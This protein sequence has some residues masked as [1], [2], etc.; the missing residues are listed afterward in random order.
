MMAKKPLGV[1]NQGI[2]KTMRGYHYLGD[3]T[4]QLALNIISTLIGTITYFYTDKVGIAAAAVGTIL[5]ISKVIDAFT[6]IVMGRIVDLTESKY[7]KVRHWFWWMAIPSGLAIVALFCVPSGAGPGFKTSYALITNILVMSV[8]YT[9]IAIPYGCLMVLRTKSTEERSKMGIVRAVFG[10][11]SGMIIA[12]ALIPITNALGGNQSAW[13]KVA[14]VFGLVSVISML[15]TF[16]TSKEENQGARLTEK[17]A[18][19]KNIAFTESLGLLFRNKYWVIMLFAMLIVNTIYS[20]TSAIGVYYAKYIL[21]NDNLVGIMGAVGL[22][23]VAAGFAVIGPMIKKF[24]LTRSCR[25]ALLIGIV[26]TS[27]RVFMPTSFIVTL[28]FGSIATFGIIPMTAVG[29]VLV[30]NT[31]EYNEWKFGKRLMGM[32]NSASSFGAKIGSGLGAAMIGWILALGNYNG[33]LAVQPESAKMMILVLSIHL[34]LAL[35]VIMYFLL[36]KYDLD[37][38]YP[39]IVKELAE[40]K[41]GTSIKQDITI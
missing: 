35:L 20:L 26:A 39:R 2:Q 19:E 6:D 23:S 10:Y 27:V 13:I 41:R 28:I 16:F 12:I 11:L 7:G 24:G 40:R 30:N 18:A 36:R 37:E 29:G 8:V 33:N 1:D 17:S 14:V 4:G 3:G 9:A 32:V 38:K 34:P 21:F 5:L 25:I 31:V 15:I 22:L